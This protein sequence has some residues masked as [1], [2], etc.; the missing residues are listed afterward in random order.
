MT[1]LATR[2]GRHIGNA[3]VTGK[4]GP[5]TQIVTDA[6]NILNLTRNELNELFHPPQYLMMHLLEAHLRALIEEHPDERPSDNPE[7]WGTAPLH[8]PTDDEPDGVLA[9]RNH[10][11][12]YYDDTGTIG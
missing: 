3:V 2:N 1:A 9:G 4:K 10:T 12:P 8:A 5:Y 6:G 7:Q 11:G